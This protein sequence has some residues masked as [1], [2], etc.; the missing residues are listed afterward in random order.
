MSRYYILTEHKGVEIV[1][2]TTVDEYH[3]LGNR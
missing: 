3:P 1:E 2:A